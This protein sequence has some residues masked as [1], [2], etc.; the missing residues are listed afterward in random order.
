VAADGGWF[1]GRPRVQVRRDGAWVEVGAQRVS[2]AYPG[3]ASAGS[4][5]TYTLTFP[6]VETDGVRV[7]GVPGGPS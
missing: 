1:T 5:M 4:N 2:P 3:G 6:A 7:I